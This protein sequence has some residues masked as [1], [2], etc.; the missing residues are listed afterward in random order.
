M[1]LGQDFGGRHQRA[2][3]AGVDTHCRGQRSHHRLASAH[4]A[5]QQA[6]HGHGAGQVMGDF[7]AHA[8]LGAGEGEGQHGQQRFMQRARTIG[9]GLPGRQHGRPQAVALAPRH[10]LRQLL[11]QQLLGLQPLPGRVAVVFQRGQG[12]VGRGVVQK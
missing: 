11:R 5:L 4:I 8:A 1:L 6:V 10:Q 12:Y 2:L 7:L 9:H 3:P